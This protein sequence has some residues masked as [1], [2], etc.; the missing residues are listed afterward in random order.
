MP[1]AWEGLI[2]FSSKE[3]QDFAALLSGGFD[4]LFALTSDVKLL[5]KNQGQ[6]LSLGPV[7]LISDVL[8]NRQVQIRAFVK[9][10]SFYGQADRKG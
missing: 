9:K 5:C 8:Q 1:A 6:L 3:A 7:I 2:Y 4:F 10:R